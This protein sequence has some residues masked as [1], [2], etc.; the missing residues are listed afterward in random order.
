MPVRPRR[1]GG[2][3]GS[4]LPSPSSARTDLAGESLIPDGSLIPTRKT[5]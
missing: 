1:P 5:S 2:L 3:V 4:T